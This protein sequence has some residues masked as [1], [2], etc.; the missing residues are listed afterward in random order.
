MILLSILGKKAIKGFEKKY[1][2]SSTRNLLD[3]YL[4][5]SNCYEKIEGY[6]NAN[7]YY[8]KYG[9][10]YEQ[11]LDP[12]KIHVLNSIKNEYKSSF[13]QKS[14]KLLEKNQFKKVNYC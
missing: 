7:F 4:L 5:L 10:C 6:K 11:V 13:L 12:Q 8:E 9:Q 2:F 3:A 14:N 1:Q